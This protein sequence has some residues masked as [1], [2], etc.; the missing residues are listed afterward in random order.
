MS[1]AT[2]ISSYLVAAARDVGHPRRAAIGKIWRDAETHWNGPA[3]FQREGTIL[4]LRDC[5][6]EHTF[7]I[8]GHN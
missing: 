6:G 4:I 2:A 3:Y 8:D 7:V 5:T 1:A